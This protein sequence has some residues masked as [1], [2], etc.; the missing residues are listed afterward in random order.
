[1]IPPPSADE[2]RMPSR[3]GCAEV[4]KLW[5]S[6]LQRELL[7]EAGAIEAVVDATIAFPTSLKVQY[8]GCQAISLLAAGHDKSRQRLMAAGAGG[9]LTACLQRFSQDQVR[10]PD[11]RHYRHRKPEGKS[12]AL[13]AIDSAFSFSTPCLLFLHSLLPKR[14]P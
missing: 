10:H 8:A 6:Q 1:M 2:A 4:S 3:P 5:S 11:R 9:V 14:R 12:T 13:S 7:R